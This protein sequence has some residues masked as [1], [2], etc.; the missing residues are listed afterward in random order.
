MGNEPS[1]IMMK[2]AL[3]DTYKLMDGPRTCKEMSGFHTSPRLEKYDFIR[4]VTQAGESSKWSM[5]FGSGIGP[6][7]RT[8]QCYCYDSESNTVYIAY[9]MGAKG[10]CF[11]DMWAL[12]VETMKWRH[13]TN[14]LL[15][16]RSNCSAAL[17]GDLMYVVG[18]FNEKEYFSELHAINIHTGKIF[19]CEAENGPDAARDQ[20]ITHYEGKLFVWGGSEML[21]STCMHIYDI[22][23]NK[24]TK[25][26]TD[27]AGRMD[28]SWAR[29]EDEL[30]I[31]GASKNNSLLKY[32]LK[33]RQFV[34]IA[35]RG[36]GPDTSA[37][38]PILVAIDNEY[39]VVF[40]G[41]AENTHSCVYLYDCKD[42][43]WLIL[44]VL[45]DN[46]SLCIADG[47]I[48]SNG[49]F[50][51]P[52]RSSCCSCYCRSH[53]KIVYFLGSTEE[54]LIPIYT[55]SIGNSLA[56]LHHRSDMLDMLLLSREET[57]HKT[58]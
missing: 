46:D 14:D 5:E 12:N 34:G 11:R 51:L 24:W 42:N 40:G 49:L 10:T 3:E 25:I 16:P 36:Q 2:V 22:S 9:G 58:D 4:T 17:V 57:N 28:A 6:L 55:I 47:D 21:V 13:V 19:K 30:W 53:R 52:R 38:K 32:D 48:T 7:S 45:P 33:E 54:D 18:G 31:F 43:I 29:M 35:Q 8:G 1:S 50:R 39:L 26:Q 15:T 37:H 41:N 20:V 44:P 27:I 23:K 56:E